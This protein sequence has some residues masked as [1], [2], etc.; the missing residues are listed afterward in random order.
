MNYTTPPQM[1]YPQDFTPDREEKKKIRRNYNTVGLVLLVLNVLTIVICTICYDIFCP[2]IVYD[3][4]G[5]TVM[6]FKEMIIGGCFPAIIAMLTFGGYCLFTRYSPSE[7]FRTDKVKGGEVIRYVLIILM[8][9]QVSFFCTIIMSNGLY[10]MGLEVPDVNMVYEHKPSVYAVDVI[11]SVIL[12]PIGEELIYRGIV[13][14]SCAKVSQRFAIFFSAF[15]FGIMHGNPYQFL[16]GF[17]LGIPL[18]II[19][20]RTGSLIPAIICHMANNAFASIPTVVEYFNADAAMIINILYIPLFL[21][22]GIFA[23][24]PEIVSGRMKIPEYTEY[25]RKRTLPIM[26]T[27]WSVIIAMVIFLWELITSIQPIAEAAEEMM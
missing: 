13:L 1:Y 20:I 25:H 18:A 24:V 15:V 6:G 11:A 2:E 5:M 3:D 19:T 4:Y 26:V 8:F 14:R 17:L 16:L 27:S 9:Q 22:V 10:A 7:L 21:L 12:A 23:F